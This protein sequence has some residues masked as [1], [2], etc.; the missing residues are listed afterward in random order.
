MI[1]QQAIIL[2]SPKL[3]AGLDVKYGLTNNLTMDLTIN[4]DFA[5]VEADDEQINLTRFSLFSL[6]KELFFR[7]GRVFLPLT[8]NRE[9]SFLQQKNR[10]Q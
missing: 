4:T 7:K 5:Q 10:T 8:L 3:N 9:Q 6:K 2:K 1:F